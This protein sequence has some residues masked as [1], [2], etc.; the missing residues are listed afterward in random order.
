[1]GIYFPPHWSPS[2]ASEQFF[3]LKLGYMS[4]KFKNRGERGTRTNSL[5]WPNSIV[6]HV[7]FRCNCTQECNTKTCTCR[8]H[9]I[10]C[11]IVCGNCKGVSCSN[12]T[13]LEE[14]DHDET[15]H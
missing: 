8:K 13:I 6:K 1:M 7:L 12:C 10:D 14:T 9:G 4:A 3:L 11:S 2:K 5:C 15:E